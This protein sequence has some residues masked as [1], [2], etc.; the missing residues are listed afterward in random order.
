MKRTLVKILC[1]TL[2]GAQLLMLAGC[3]KQ[4]YSGGNGPAPANGPSGANT[5]SMGNG[6]MGG[7]GG[8]GPMGGGNG[9]H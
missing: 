1:L 7:G 2:L 8:N 4:V 3:G 5:P 6:P 9:P